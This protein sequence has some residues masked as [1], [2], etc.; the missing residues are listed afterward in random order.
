MKIYIVCFLGFLWGLNP[1]QAQDVVYARKIIKQLTSPEFAG[2]GYVDQGDRKAAEYIAKEFSASGLS[3]FQTE[4]YFQKFAF[5]VNRFPYEVSIKLDEHELG[6]G[7]DYIVD[8]GCITI[9]GVYELISI[10]SE[11][12][13]N[14][15]K[16]KRFLKRKNYNKFLVIDR[17]S[18]ANVQQKEHIKELMHGAARVHGLVILD[19]KLTWTVATKQ[20][21][22]PKVYIKREAFK[23][24]PQ[25]IKLEINSDFAKGHGT[26]NV[27]AYI[28]GSKYPDSFIVYTAHYDHLG[29]MGPQAYFPGANDNASGVAMLLD[30]ARYY[31]QHKPNCSIAF[32]CFA[33]EEAGLI[34]SQFYVYHP[35]FPLKQIVFLVNMD[36]MGTGE[37]G[38]TVVNATEF[39]KEFDTLVYL[40]TVYGFLPSIASRGKAA[41]SD[42]YWFSENGVKCFF[43]YLMGNYTFY[44]DIY[45][46]NEALPLN[47]YENCVKLIQQF[48]ETIAPK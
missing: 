10:D 25:E 40:N 2:R 16:Y 44:H 33:G 14:A 47:K 18:L 31:A 9:N 19:D 4:D 17:K 22:L 30:L 20:D 5:P 46:T 38:M 8:A 42:H 28:K 24:F 11:T 29:K 26:Q 15:G 45:D 39:K 3:S 32:I 13:D 43:F 1:T 35:L 21:P 34:G 36:L 12:I 27:A 37:K 48:T 41:N 6:A 23:N 7:S